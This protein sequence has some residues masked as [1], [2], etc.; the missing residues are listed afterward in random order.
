MCEM[1]DNSPVTCDKLDR[2]GLLSDIEGALELLS[3]LSDAIDEL[4]STPSNPARRL[5]A[6]C[7][8]GAPMNDEIKR[9]K[10]ACSDLYALY[11]VE[12]PKN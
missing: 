11:F 1:T 3:G 8:I 6:I 9:A 4:S 12:N 5:S 10:Q 7:A 2:F